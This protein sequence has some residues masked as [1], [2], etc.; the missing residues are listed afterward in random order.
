MRRVGRLLFKKVCP[1][2]VGS[3][4]GAS[5]FD[6]MTR[7][8][9]G[10]Q[11]ASRPSTWGGGAWAVTN[12][13]KRDDSRA[14]TS[15]VGTGARQREGAGAEVPGTLI[16]RFTHQS[17]PARRASTVDMTPR[18]SFPPVPPFF[19][20]RLCF[21]FVSFEGV[22]MMYI[23]IIPPTPPFFF[24]ASFPPGRTFYYYK[25]R[26]MPTALLEKTV[27]VNADSTPAL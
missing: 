17:G 3:R 1:A 26:R 15:L 25:T 21:V 10:P 8:G 12:T 4:W 16:G 7:T 14:S 22:A 5:G 19:L 23:F 27:R 20:V 18:G 11:V 24:N 9:P 6:V 13:R 2:Q